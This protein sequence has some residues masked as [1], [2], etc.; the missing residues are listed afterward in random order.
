MDSLLLASSVPV[1]TGLFRIHHPKYLFGTIIIYQ[2]YKNAYNF[3][4]ESLFIMKFI[5]R[6]LALYKMIHVLQSSTLC[7]KVVHKE[8]VQNENEL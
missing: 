4:K 2:Y 6:P 8:N 5:Y 1:F 3:L 7:G